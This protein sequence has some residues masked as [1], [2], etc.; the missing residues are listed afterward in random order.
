MSQ[1]VEVF[2]S[3][4]R[5]DERLLQD[6]KIHLEPLRLSGHISIWHDGQI[7]PGEEWDDQIKKNLDRSQIIV[8]LISK[9]FINS[10]YIQKV[11]LKTAYERHEKGDTIIIPVILR[12]CAW[13]VVPF[14]SKC[15][16]DLQALPRGAKPIANWANRDRAFTNVV[17]EIQHIIEKQRM[18]VLSSSA[19]LAKDEELEL[20]K[21]WEDVVSIIKPLGTRAL[22]H[23]QGSLLFFD[24]FNARVGIG[25][26]PLFRMAQG[27]IENI[28][29]AFQEIFKKKIDVS[30]EVIPEEENASC[31]SDPPFY[32]SDPP[33]GMNQEAPHLN[34]SEAKTYKWQINDRVSHKNYG[35]GEITHI[36]GAGEKICL[37]INFSGC[38]R[39]IIDPK[40]SPLSR[41]K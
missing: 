24:G 5:K 30:L 4:S 19:S 33:L 39:R 3:Y 29:E 25:S 31:S 27:R 15:L 38:G 36:F 17:E 22:M 21:I 16:G 13:K 2:L 1:A 41:E 40:T 11:E 18:G 12:D 37:A 14:G 7:V 8:L 34:S 10:R 9:Y 32:P 26:K 35:I 20:G 28:E 23:Q 6:I